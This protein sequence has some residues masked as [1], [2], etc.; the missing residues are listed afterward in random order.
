M[1]CF[2]ERRGATMTAERFF[3]SRFGLIFSAI[4]A[5]FLWGSAFPFIK[6]SYEEL[7]ITAD[8]TGKQ[9]LFAGYRFVLAAVLIFIFSLF[10]KRKMSLKRTDVKELSMIGLFQ[11]FLQYVFFY[12]GLAYSTGVQGSII[13]GTTTFFQMIIAHFVYRD[14]PLDKRKIIGLTI[15]FSGVV[16]VNLTKG[17]FE[18]SFGIGESFLLLAMLFAGIGNVLAKEGSSRINV[19]T[20]TTVQMLFGGIGLLL[21]GATFAGWMPFVITVKGM[22][23]FLYLAFLSATGFVLWNFVMKYNKVGKVSMFL[24]LIPIFGVFL[25]AVLLKEALSFYVFLGL[26][27]VVFGIIVVNFEKERVND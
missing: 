7:H 11:T 4:L 18:L 21:V 23:M 17:S 5:T 1:V 24:F 8:E 10:M 26:A 25:S 2:L 22:C 16:M 27:L 15:G 14:D 6:L 12:I 19:I 20:L 13:A 3:T 9:I